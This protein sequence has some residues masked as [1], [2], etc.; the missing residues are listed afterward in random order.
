MISDIAKQLYK[1]VDEEK[2]LRGKPLDAVIA[3]SIF[4]ACCQAHV[5]RT[6]CEICKLTNVPKNMLVQY[7]KALEKAFNLTLGSSAA[8]A[9]DAKS[10]T[11]PKTF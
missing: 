4:I 11:S 2:L 8:R 7:Y 5:A 6:F 10:V 3:T 1:R 9:D